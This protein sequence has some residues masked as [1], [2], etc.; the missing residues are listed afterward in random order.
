MR[1]RKP[2]ILL[3]EYRWNEELVPRKKN[4]WEALEFS[5]SKKERIIIL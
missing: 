1:L 5:K 2:S 3:I 4:C